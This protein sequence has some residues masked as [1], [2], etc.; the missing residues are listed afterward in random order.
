MELQTQERKTRQEQK[1]SKD[2]LVEGGKGP[3][4]IIP[5]KQTIQANSGLGIRVRSGTE[6]N[7]NR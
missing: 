4:T 7:R 6:N 5:I 1:V 3:K 2:N